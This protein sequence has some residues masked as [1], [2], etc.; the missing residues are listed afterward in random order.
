M[1]RFADRL[2]YKDWWNST[3]FSDY[4][5]TWNL[6]V[7]DWLYTY[8]YQDMYMVSLSF[9]IPSFPPSLLIPFLPL[10]S[11][12][13]IPY[14]P[15]YVLHPSLTLFRPSSPIGQI[16]VNMSGSLQVLGFQRRYRWIA[17]YTTFILSAIFHEYILLMCFKFFY[18]VNFVLFGGF[19][20][21]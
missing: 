5:R 3:G 21:G 8:V 17:M 16:N 4:Y 13:L 15:L 19:G 12:S 6:V 11:L 9:L 10:F 7:H 14:H 2:F 1:L 20:G 18:P